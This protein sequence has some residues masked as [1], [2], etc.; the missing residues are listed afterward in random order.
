MAIITSVGALDEYPID[1][2]IPD[3][4]LPKKNSRVLG[5][6]ILTMDKDALGDFITRLPNEIMEKV[7]SALRVS[8]DLEETREE[9][10]ESSF[11]T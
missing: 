6:T 7:D 4:I 3:G 10:E 9:Q 1:V 5:A 11:E 2:L 8:L